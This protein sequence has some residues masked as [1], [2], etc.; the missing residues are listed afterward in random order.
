MIQVRNVRKDG[1]KNNDNG[2]VLQHNFR[3][4]R[5]YQEI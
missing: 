3:E 4:Y 2:F 5:G 1:N